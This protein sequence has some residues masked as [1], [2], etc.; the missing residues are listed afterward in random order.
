MADMP[1]MADEIRPPVAS[2]GPLGWVRANLLD[3]WY[4]ALLTVAVVA[5]L[6][7]M[8]RGFAG[9]A[10]GTAEWAVVS[11]N[12]QV[13][14]VGQYLDEE[15]WRAG[16]VMLALP[17]V[18]GLGW[19]V[20]PGFCRKLAISLAVA[21]PLLAALPVEFASLG[22]G[23][24]IF[25][26]LNTVLV[27]AGWLVG[28][29][30]VL[31]QARWVLGTWLVLFLGGLVFLRGFNA[32][33]ALPFVGTKQWGGLM[34]TLL[35]A[36][37]GIVISFPL[38]ILFALGRRSSMAFVRVACIA[39]IE[40][41]RGTP[42]LAL[43][44]VTQVLLPLLLP[45]WMDMDR[46]TRGLIALILNNSAYMAENIRGGLQSVPSGQL[47]AARALG[48]KV[49][50]I[51]VR[52]VLPQALRN[53]LPAIVGQFIILFKDT[54]V[55]SLLGLLDFLGTAN[56][57]LSGRRMWF[58]SEIEMFV[59][60]AAVYWVFTY[61]MTSVSRAIERSMSKGVG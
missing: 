60:A 33:E 32:S 3:T 6:Y 12:L 58:N 35:L 40:V 37:A 44:F 13:L 5:A 24:R 18:L 11:Q 28:R 30:T 43:L 54:A 26:L 38:G 55:I 45:D 19:S 22:A 41:L 48:M 25:L 49:H 10:L 46:L 57:I 42:I 56:A 9:W 50:H 59:F 21:A 15:V 1:D 47:E 36:Q 8:V 2:T 39:Y 51:T 34:V 27:G 17:F 23:F 16:A 4:N 14:L 29:Y 53:V 20:W 31:G 52:I 7:Y 61:A